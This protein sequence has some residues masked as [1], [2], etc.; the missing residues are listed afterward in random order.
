MKM[1]GLLLALLVVGWLVYGQLN[2]SAPSAIVTDEN[3][4]TPRVPTTPQQLEQFDQDINQ[5]V[6][7][8]AAE[9]TRQIEENQ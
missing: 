9:R 6:I 8:S 5:F 1:I 3:D 4:T 7:D 2:L